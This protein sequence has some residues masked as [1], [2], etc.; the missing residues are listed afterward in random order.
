MAS[1]APMRSQLRES[2]M[3]A[4]KGRA[5][6]RAL[7]HMLQTRAVQ[8]KLTVNAPGDELERE[9]DR[10]ADQVMRMPNSVVVDSRSIQRACAHCR[11]ELN[12]NRIQ[13]R[14]SECDEALQRE[15]RDNRGIPE[16]P[17][18][19]ASE[20]ASIRTGGEPLPESAQEFFQHRF[21]HDFS[22]VRVHAR[23]RAAETAREI[24]AHAYT[25]RNH[26]VFAPGLYTPE[27]AAG[28]R[29]LA[30]ELSHT[31]QQGEG[32]PFPGE[33]IQRLGDLARVPAG[34]PCAVAPATPPN[35]IVEVLFPNSGTI[36]TAGQK[37][38]IQDF[39]VS[40]NASGA[41]TSVR[42]D[43]YASP[44]GADELNWRLSCERA[45]A[46]A[47]EL[48]VP[49]SPGIPAV[50]S[51]KLNIFAQGETSEFS[52]TGGTDP[53]GPNRRAA[54][55]ALPPPPP[56]QPV[57]APAL[58]P[59]VPTTTPA[60]CAERHTAYCAAQ[61]CFPTNS[62]LSCVCTASGQVCDAADAFTFT[63]PTGTALATCAA[64]PPTAPP[65]PIV[66]KGSWFL[67]TNQCI[68]GHWRAAFD[69]IHDPTLAIPSGVTP[70]WSAAITT[71]RTSGIGSNNC[72]EAQV[73]AE[74]NA[75][76]RCS[77]YN[78]AAFGLLP[79]DVP[80]APFCS[81]IVAAAAP[82]PAFTGD[83]GKVADRIT[84]G[85]SRCCT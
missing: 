13:R 78:S 76:D 68:W 58:C 9:A 25:M 80:G 70:E 67:S 81:R 56:P 10:V 79:T 6:N 64:T 63:G 50:P 46:V 73:V 14:C 51:G 45:Q 57:P 30:H 4:R 36:L 27:T 38:L 22:G 12:Q 39:A 53:D 5:G 72:C 31:I 8:P 49:S 2:T 75:I 47:A 44:A 52:R 61:T 15:P 37:K 40:W 48:L 19:L 16:I 59:A 29:L 74:Q 3:V 65:G 7:Q 41:S 77:P 62:W 23:G 24:G 11:K 85:K 82:P 69:A 1:Y 17:E 20:I 28:R 42:V 21:G 60:T 33:M 84:Y 18:S 34:L 71:C 35:A 54:I 32:G 43:G 83:F 66:S 26:I 55:S